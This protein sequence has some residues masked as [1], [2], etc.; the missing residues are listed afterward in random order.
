[1]F[2]ESGGIP[3]RRMILGGCTEWKVFYRRKHGAWELV[4]KE[5]KGFHFSDKDIFFK[6]KRK[7]RV[8]ITQIGSSSCAGVG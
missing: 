5:K 7:A 2:H 1:M 6:G 4:T 3:F 8:F